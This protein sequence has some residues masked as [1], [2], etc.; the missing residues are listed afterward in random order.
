MVEG[1]SSDEAQVTIGKLNVIAI[2]TFF[3]G[4]AKLK[5]NAWNHVYLR[6]CTSCTCKS[7]LILVYG[8]F[9]GQL[10]V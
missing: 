5:T 7:I 4:D 1:S 9:F 8:I 6:V 2:N 10:L 3:N